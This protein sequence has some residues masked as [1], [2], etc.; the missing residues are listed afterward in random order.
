FARVSLKPQERKNVMFTLGPRDFSVWVPN[1]E[2]K[3]GKWEVIAGEYD[4]IVGST[5]DPQQLTGDNGIS[6]I[7]TV[8]VTE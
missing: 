2:T 6:L 5:S 3:S 8:N 7:E 1:Q 4:I